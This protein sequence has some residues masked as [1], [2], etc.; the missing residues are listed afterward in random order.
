MG[1][2]SYNIHVHIL[3]QLWSSRG[4]CCEYFHAWLLTP[5]IIVIIRDSHY[6]SIENK[7]F[8]EHL[9]RAAQL[10]LPSALA[11]G[12]INRDLLR[13]FGLL[14]RRVRVGVACAGAGA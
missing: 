9:L 13:T 2:N 4:P 12:N 10:S 14:R 7:V 8:I 5:D 3:T 11:R 6:H 1:R